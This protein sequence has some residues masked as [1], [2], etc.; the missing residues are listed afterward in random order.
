MAMKTM[1]NTWNYINKN[2]LVGDSILTLVFALWIFFNLRAY[3]VLQPP[4]VSTLLAVI[5]ISL[6]VIP[7]I[8]LRIFP[9]IALLII[10]AAAVTLLV[11][12]IQDMN[13]KGIILILAVFSASTYGGQ[14][15]DVV[16]V[17]CIVA[18]I[19]G[20]IYSL[21]LMGSFIGNG[22]LFS[23]TPAVYNLLIFL[24]VWWLGKTLRLSREQASQLTESTEQL[25]RE[26]EDNARRAVFDERIRIA[27]ELHDVLAHHV[28]VMGIQAG[29]ARQVLKQYP[30]KA[31]NSLSLI[32]KSSRQAVAELYRLLDLLRDEKQVE[33]FTSQPGLQQLDKLVSDMEDAG[34]K[35]EIK[36]EGEQREIPQLIDLSAYRIIEEALTNILKHSHA[37]IATI[38]MVFQNGTLLLDITDNGHG[39]PN[40][41]KTG[42]GGR[43]LIGM[44]ERVNLVKGEFQAGND[45]NGGFRIKVK[46]PLSEQR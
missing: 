43:G 37:T 32:E 8:W 1:K 46:L 28:S 7:L 29:A 33:S 15:R 13:F 12:N 3:W 42:S 11:L 14:K 27:R 10:T 18:I 44:R 41:G 25:L 39:I 21:H 40:E 6:E 26:R 22:V 23:I 16:S 34:L 30:E 31:L 9:S 35:V 24:A 45:P 20:L 36:M 4:P 38:S 17:T 5:L 2:P 19:G